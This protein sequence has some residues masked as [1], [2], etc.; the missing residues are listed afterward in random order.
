MQ[1]FGGPANWSSTGIINIRWGPDPC[2]CWET[3]RNT[4]VSNLLNTEQILFILFFWQ[5]TL[6]KISKDLP[7][8]GVQEICFHDVHSEI[9]HLLEEELLEHSSLYQ[10]FSSSF[11][12]SLK[13]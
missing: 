11:L 2:A 4:Y 5:L 8:V 3:L 12:L 13:Q 7:S 1:N 9:C 10:T 6:L